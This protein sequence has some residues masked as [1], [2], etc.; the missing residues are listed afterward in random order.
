MYETGSMPRF[1]PMLLKNLIPLLAMAVPLTAAPVFIG[2]NTGGKGGSKGIYLTDFDDATGKLGEVRLVA[3]YRN[4]GFLAQHPSK[5]ILY[6]CGQPTE[7][8]QDGSDSVAA[9]TIGDDHA[10]KFLG[11]SSTKGRGACHVAVDATGRT[12][13]VA[14]YGDGSYATVKLAE[15]GTP[16]EAASVFKPK[17]NGPN[18][19]RQ[20]GPHAHGVYFNK[21]NTRFFMPDLGRDQIYIHPFD[22][23]TSKL[24]DAMPPVVSKPG[25]GPRHL[26]LSPDEN[27]MYVINELDNTVTVNRK[28]GDTYKAMETL[29]TLAQD[30]K[31]VSTTAEIEVHPNGKFVYGSNRGEDSI[32]VY[33]RDPETGE[34]Q[35]L[36]RASCGGKGPRHFKISPSG[37]WLLCAHQSSNT[38]SVLSLDT[39]TG[40]LGNPENTV[41]APTPICLLFA[42]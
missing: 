36:Q 24:G 32:V 42:R 3:E 8:Y 23:A 16:G 10:L 33:Q 12:L 27:E 34:L 6:A 17:G 37:K 35:F 20:E 14:N 18:K 1:V 26:A 13:A 15:D 31:G 9:F 11:E 22:A 2:T 19:G 41:D 28:E 21:E 7:A 40:M 25:A 5:P 30:F 39:A 38:I 4:P 29:P